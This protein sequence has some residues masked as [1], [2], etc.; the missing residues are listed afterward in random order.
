[1]TASRNRERRTL[2]VAERVCDVLQAQAVETAVIGA[3]ALAVH[4]YVRSTREFDLATHA[5]PFLELTEVRR[6]LKEAGLAAVLRTP[7]AEDPL[8]GLIEV[9]GRAFKPIQIVNFLN[10]LRA[11]PH[12]DRAAHRSSS[13]AAGLS[14]D[15][16][17]R[18]AEGVAKRSLHF[19]LASVREDSCAFADAIER[20]RVD[21]VEV[22]H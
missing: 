11:I 7:D 22:G 3:M 5:D 20:H 12:G 1:V 19:P 16:Q 17:L 13:R 2:E 10:P 14:E 8:G 18:S 4:G 15:L 9:T 6:A 21:V